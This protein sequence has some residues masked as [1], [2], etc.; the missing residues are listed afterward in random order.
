MPAAEW[1][2]CYTGG[3]GHLPLGGQNGLAIHTWP[4]ELVADTDPCEQATRPLTAGS[5]NVHMDDYPIA[6]IG[7]GR[8]L[9]L[10]TGVD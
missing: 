9:G 10:A 2:L 3:V 5:G 1:P 7:S 8:W 4:T 6:R